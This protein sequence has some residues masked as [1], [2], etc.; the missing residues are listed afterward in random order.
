M[1]WQVPCKGGHGNK[2]SMSSC[3]LWCTLIISIITRHFI[4]MYSIK[5]AIQPEDLTEQMYRFAKDAVCSRASAGTLHA[6]MVH[7][8]LVWYTACLYGTLH[9]GMVH[10]MLV[11]YTACWY[12][13]LHAGMV[14]CMLV[15]YT[16]CWYG[17]LH[18]GM[19][20]N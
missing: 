5:K 10:C 15:W 19:R 16:A 3:L 11:W 8:M 17:T 13:T 2:S 7:C 1:A 14:H 12:G 9:A 4:H 6:G 18:A 20:R